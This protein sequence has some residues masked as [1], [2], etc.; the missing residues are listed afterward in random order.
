MIKIKKVLL[1]RLS[2]LG[3]VIFNIPLA[4][5][6]K[7]AGYELTW[8]VSEKGYK[9]VK[10]NPCVDDVIFV[11]LS[12]WKKEGFSFRCF[13]EIFELIKFIRSKKFD[14][15][16]DCQM[17]F[18]SLF[19]LLFCGAKRRITSMYAKELSVIAGNEWVNN[20]F[21]KPKCHIVSNYL[22]YAKYLGVSTEQIKVSLPKR[23]D[24]QIKK[25]DKLLK[26]IDKTKPLVILAPATTWDNKHW[27][28]DNWQVLIGKIKNRCN[29][30]FSGG[31]KEFEYVENIN[32]ARFLNLAGKTNIL[33]L[34]EVFSRADVVISPDSGSAHLA[35]ASGKPAVVTIFT[36]TPKNIL[37]PFGDENK[38]IALGGEGLPCQ[39]CYSKKCKKNKEKNYCKNYPNPQI[40]ADVVENLI[41]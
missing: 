4:N 22:N 19:W 18:K 5:A 26:N 36:C 33:E 29:I 12:K 11:P 35:W 40:V 15:A 23:S 9:L 13:S 37:A 17:M 8:L 14:I 31:D 27:A 6:L 41:F 10:N 34:A 1:I 20:V 38:Y 7:S 3:D 39:P 24:K 2:S 28:D 25:I 32:K 16:I 21:Y 30:V